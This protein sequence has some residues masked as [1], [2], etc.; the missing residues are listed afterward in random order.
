MDRSGRLWVF[1]VAGWLWAGAAIVAASDGS[2]DLAETLVLM[3][4]GGGLYLAWI[5][6]SFLGPRLSRPAFLT[7]MSVPVAG[8]AAAVLAATNLPLAARLWLGE[9]ALLERARDD[10]PA[11]SSRSAPGWI[12]IFRVTAVER[13][14]GAVL[15][16]TGDTALM[17]SGSGYSP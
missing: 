8:A 7:W 1:V 12:G 15:F 13:T 3:T 4:T 14:D 11:Q 6:R 9:S 5:G 16:V 10:S 17:Y 2:L